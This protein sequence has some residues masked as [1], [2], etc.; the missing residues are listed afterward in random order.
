MTKKLVDNEW[1]TLMCL[2]KFVG[3][4]MIINFWQM[5]HFTS[6]FAMM[7]FK[8]NASALLAEQK[9]VA[10]FQSFNHTTAI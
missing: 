10:N 9:I 1:V 2:K 3:S 6:R 4:C 7:T 8:Q 5:G